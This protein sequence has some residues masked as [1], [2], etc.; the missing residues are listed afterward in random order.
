MGLLDKAS[1]KLRKKSSRAGEAVREH[2]RHEAERTVS[3]LSKELG[4]PESREELISLCY[5]V[6]GDPAHWR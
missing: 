3:I 2:N 5:A 1:A 4:L 6:Q